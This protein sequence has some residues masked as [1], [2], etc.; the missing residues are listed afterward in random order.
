MRYMFLIYDDESNAK[1]ADPEIFAEYGEF[2]ATVRESGVFLS[3]DPLQPTATSTT[4][5]MRDGQPVVTDGPFAETKEQLRGYYILD[6]KDPTRRCS[7]PR[8]SRPPASGRSRYARSSRCSAC[9]PATTAPAARTPVSNA[10]RTH[11][12][13]SGFDASRR[14]DD[15]G[16]PCPLSPVPYP[17][18]RSP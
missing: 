12:G 9:G 3:G 10:P 2:S 5:R 18:G 11:S 17:F 13:R 16:V 4:V 14:S 7:T 8:R 1:G 6:C 15:D